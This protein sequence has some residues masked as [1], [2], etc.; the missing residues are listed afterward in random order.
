MREEL[1][2]APVASVVARGTK[3]LGQRHVDGY[4]YPAHIAQ[5]IEVPVCIYF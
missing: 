3:V 2:H 1:I 4:Y 5:E